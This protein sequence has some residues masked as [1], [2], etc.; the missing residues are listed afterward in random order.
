M[1]LAQRLKACLTEKGW[2][3]NQ[4]DREAKL[5]AGSTKRYLEGHEPNPKS[6][7]RLGEFF[8]VDPRELFDSQPPR[9][10]PEPNGAS[11]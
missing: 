8:G 5:S 6:L 7:R 3:P 11:Q 9:P 10:A 4:L 2:K 1:T